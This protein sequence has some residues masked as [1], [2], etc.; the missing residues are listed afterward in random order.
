[1]PASLGAG[2]SQPNAA[3][4]ALVRICAQEA[5]HQHCEPGAFGLI[6]HRHRQ[7]FV[8][9]RQQL[10]PFAVGQKAVVPH[11]FKMPSR[12]MADIAL[13]HLFLADFFAFILLRTVIVILMDHGTA[14]I[15]PEL[16]SRHWRALQITA[17]VFHAAPGATG[18]FGEVYFPCSMILRMEVAVPPVIVTDMA[19]ARQATGVDTCIV[20]TQQVNDGVAPDLLYVFLFKEQLSPDVVFGIEAAAGDGDVDMR[21]LIELPA[22]GVLRAKDADFDPLPAGPAEHGPG[23][24]AKQVVEQGPVVIEER[25]QQVG[26]G[27]GDMLPVAVGQD[28]QLLGNP[29]LGGLEAA[30]AGGLG[31]AALAEDAGMGT[32]G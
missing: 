18:L 32:V 29:L 17:K 15:M 22:V 25:P 26:H 11:H 31:L 13:Q 14:A 2:K 7:H 1:M 5:F 27:E 12:N 9:L 20:V 10:A 30:T 24:A 21:V 8:D 6:P 23:S 3:Q 19:E 28:V 4:D 16:G